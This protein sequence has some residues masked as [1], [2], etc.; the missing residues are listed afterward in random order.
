[1][2]FASASQIPLKPALITCGIRHNIQYDRRITVMSE[3]V[4]WREWDLQGMQVTQL[5]FGHE[6]TIV[7]WS[8]ERHFSITFETQVSFRSADAGDTI[9]QPEQPSTLSPLLSLLHRPAACFRVSPDG[10]CRLQFENSDE[11]S[12]VPDDSYEAWNSH[13]SGDLA[14]AS[15]LCSPG[16]GLPWAE[17]HGR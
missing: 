2:R 12:C 9:L 17:L 10:H 7:M 5:C 16:G 8:P 13:G 11:L 3:P 6:L 1:M 15:L 4:E 14:S